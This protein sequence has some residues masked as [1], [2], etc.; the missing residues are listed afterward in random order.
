[1]SR[2]LEPAGRRAGRR[3]P[4]WRTA[5]GGSVECR[6]RSSSSRGKLPGPRRDARVVEDQA[7]GVVDELALEV[8]SGR[9][10]VVPLVGSVVVEPDVPLF[11]P[12]DAQVARGD[13]CRWR[14]GP[15]ADLQPQAM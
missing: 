10:V 12:P 7:P 11:E 9:R 8:E 13:K 5:P 6:Y 4:R 2:G 14:I 1:M 15:F 3:A